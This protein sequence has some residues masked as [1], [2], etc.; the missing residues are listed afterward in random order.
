[1]AGQVGSSARPQLLSSIWQSSNLSPAAALLAYFMLMHAFLSS[2]PWQSLPS[3]G[4]S[5]AASLKA[6][7]PDGSYFFPMAVLVKPH[8]YRL[9]EHFVTTKGTLRRHV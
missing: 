2:V 1:M 3:L 8:G 7:E 5:Q 9:Q 4:P 6:A